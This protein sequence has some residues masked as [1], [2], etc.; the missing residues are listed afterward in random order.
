M[1]LASRLQETFYRVTG[2]TELAEVVRA[3][4]ATVAHLEES[5]ADLERR[6]YEPG[7]QRLTSMAEQ[8][9]T[10][11]GLRQI[12][13]VNR[14]M[15][16]KN[17]LIKRGL[18]LRMAY[19]WG[20]GVEISARD[21]DVNALVQA[22]LDDA[23]NRR[24]LTGAQAKIENE[25]A[26][27][28]DGNLFWALF[29]NP[30]TGRVQARSIPWD[31]IADVITNPEDCSEVWYYKRVWFESSTDPITGGL[32]S[33]HRTVYYPAL[34]Y[35]PKGAKPLRVRDQVGDVAEVM[36]DAPVHHMKT[37]GDK[38]WKFGLG[39]T[40]TAIDWA[41]AYKSFLEDW[42]TLVK[43]LS[44]FA[45]KL[46]SKGSKQAAAKAR[47]ATAPTTDRYSGEPQRAGATAFTTPD[48]ALEA[49]PKSGATIDSE[50]GRPLAAMVAAALDV[51]VTM[52]LG[53]P[54]TTGARATAETLDSPTERTM[55][56]RREAWTETFQAILGYVIASAVKAPQGKLKGTVRLE[57]G[58]ETVE[59][60][61]DADDTLDI[62]WPD[63]D[64]LDP[65][66]VIEAIVKADATGYVPPLVV[67]RLLLEALGVR[68]VE[69][70]LDGLTDEDGNFKPPEGAAGQAGQA[71]VDAFRRGDDPAALLAG[72]KPDKP[73]SEDEKPPDDEPAAEPDPA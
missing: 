43:A 12:T 35:R 54:G 51:P 8:E 21:E 64:D 4:R 3:E 61:A 2:R 52:L 26:L 6:M 62:A 49:I 59:L 50:S 67:V 17:A 73:G 1:G 48:M 56:L 36:W 69:S 41:Q 39:V 23:G 27:D 13:A 34:G 5:I 68:D 37:G 24:C 15:A 55:E 22:F 19:V 32:T 14:I 57:D 7:W 60:A 31:E 18:A 66:A 29:T 58:V 38:G 33:R 20:Q 45:W 46:T 28:T 53:D 11:E 44:R 72:R 10:R 16:L 70:I 40:Y 65:G 71:A 30:R 25:K 63:I 47:M 9:F 42:A